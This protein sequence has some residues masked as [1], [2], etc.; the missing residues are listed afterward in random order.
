MTDKDYFANLYEIA[1]HLNRE[2]SLHAALRKSLEKTVELLGLETGW[3]WLVQPDVK[4]VYLAASYN[5]PPALHNHPER[6]SGWC[7]CI[8]QYLLDDITEARNISEIRCTR[9]KDVK[10]GTRDLKFHA[11]IP[12]RADGHKI[13][14][15][16]LVSA[17]SQQ[18]DDKQLFTLDT[19]GNIIGSAVQRMRLHEAY[20]T[21]PGS[22]NTNALLDVLNDVFKPKLE[23]LHATLQDSQEYHLSGEQ[24][25]IERNLRIA[26]DQADQL[27]RTLDTVISESGQRQAN[28][29]GAHQL[30]YPATLSGRE[31]EVLAL[32]KQGHT[33]KQI[34]DRLFISERTVK[35][36]LTSIL[37]KLHASTRTEAVNTALQRGLVGN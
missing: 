13:G 3:I 37:A 1:R 14:L 32:V 7:Y 12:I 16:N 2:F 9:L 19:V 28:P 17:E 10:I 15:L 23:A 18:L 29:A 6:L 5:L 22:S 34:A 24:A 36:H 27:L 20:G 26:V 4:S 8:Q 35:F 11:T 21:R 25:A 31:L 33:N 30:H